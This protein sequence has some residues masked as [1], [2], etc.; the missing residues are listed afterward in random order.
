MKITLAAQFAACKQQMLDGLDGLQPTTAIERQVFAEVR[1]QVEAMTPPE[2]EPKPEK[3]PTDPLAAGAKL[4]KLTQ[5]EIRVSGGKLTY[6]AALKRVVADP[7]NWPLVQEY[8]QSVQR[9]R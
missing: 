5:R 7:D 6:T 3:R 4:H 2:P 1:R 8:Q 9:S